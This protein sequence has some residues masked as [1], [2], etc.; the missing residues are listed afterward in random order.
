MKEFR[1]FIALWIETGFE[2]YSENPEHITKYRFGHDFNNDYCRK[3]LYTEKGETGIYK[4]PT[5]VM[6]EL[7]P[8]LIVHVRTH[9]T[10]IDKLITWLK[11]DNTIA[12]HQHHY[13]WEDFFVKQ[14]AYAIY[15]LLEEK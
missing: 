13:D 9:N 12:P 6:C 11:R 5:K 14:F 8:A 1:E 15:N 7:I 2:W 4:L 10:D 3:L